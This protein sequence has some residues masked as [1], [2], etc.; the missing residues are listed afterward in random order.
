MQGNMELYKIFYYVARCGSITKA[1]EKLGISQPAVSQAIKQIEQVFHVTFFIRTQKGTKLTKEGEVLYQ[2]VKEGYETLLLGEEKLR[3]FMNFD[4]GEVYI[5]AS[6][7]TLRYYLLPYLEEFHEQ[8][9]NIKVSITNGPTPETIQYLKEGTIDF[10]I[11]TEPLP[12]QKTEDLIVK[13]VRE[14]QDIFVAGKKFCDKK[15]SLRY[16]EQLNE[17]PLICLEKNTSTRAYIDQQLALHN[18]VLYPEFELATSDMIIEFAQRNFGIGCVVEDFARDAIK[19]G[20]LFELQ[21][22]RPMKP[23]AMYLVTQKHSSASL[24]SKNLLEMMLGE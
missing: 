3:E 2:Y 20:E 14:I 22:E 1:A 5:G 13:K 19:K 24:A 4:A 23:R 12:L 15:D 21:L 10:G 9:P 7:M 6:D 17:V 18:V 16:Y 8:Y 11:V